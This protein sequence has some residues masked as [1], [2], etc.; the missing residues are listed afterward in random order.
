MDNLTKG[1]ATQL[2]LRIADYWHQRGCSHF[3]AV[4]VPLGRF[5]QDGH[6]IYGVRSNLD[7]RGLPPREPTPASH[8]AP[9]E[10]PNLREA[11]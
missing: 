4:V 6:L 5:G 1:G 2:A 11:A 7:H 8:R 10:L 9:A 3:E